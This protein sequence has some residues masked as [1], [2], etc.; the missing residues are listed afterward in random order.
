[1][2]LELSNVK[3]KPG[4]VTVVC[5]LLC[6]FGAVIFANGLETALTL[7]DLF[8]DTTSAYRGWL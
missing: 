2:F 1:M 5:G 4:D 6:R 8:L 7:I 3:G